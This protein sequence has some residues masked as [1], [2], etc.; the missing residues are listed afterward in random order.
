MIFTG[1][2]CFV[3]REHCHLYTGKFMYLRAIRYEVMPARRSQSPPQRL[4]ENQ[5]MEGP[6]IQFHYGSSPFSWLKTKLD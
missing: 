3:L 6:D 5:D 2:K 1:G 4:V